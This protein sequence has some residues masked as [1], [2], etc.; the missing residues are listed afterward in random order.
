MYFLPVIAKQSSLLLLYIIIISFVR[1]RALL[2]RNQRRQRRLQCVPLLLP[3]L[4][5]H[6]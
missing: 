6:G 4:F 3:Q 5:R 2:L 1:V